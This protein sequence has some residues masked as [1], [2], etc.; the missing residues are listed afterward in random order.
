MI[1]FIHAADLHLGAPFVGLREF[2]SRIRDAL[3][4]APYLAFEYLVS[5]AI[6]RKVDFVLLAGD[7]F[8]QGGLNINAQIR[9]KQALE[10]LSNENI[11]VFIIY[12]NHDYLV[13]DSQML[14]YPENV[15]VFSSEGETFEYVLPNGERGSLSGFSYQGRQADGQIID[16]FPERSPKTDYHIGIWHGEVVT[17]KDSYSPYAPV[18]LQALEDKHYDY[19][20]LGHVHQSRQLNHH[21]TIAY[22]GTIQGRHVN[23]QGRKGCYEVTIDQNH[24]RTNFLETS[25][26]VFDTLD[27]KVSGEVTL[28][29]VYQVIEE[30]LDDIVDQYQKSILQLNLSINDNVSDSLKKQLDDSDYRKSLS[31]YNGPESFCYISKIHYRGL[32]SYQPLAEVTDIYDYY[33]HQE[34]TESLTSELFQKIPNHYHH[35]KKD[36]NYLKERIQ[37]AL[38]LIGGEID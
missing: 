15:F 3:F 29:K 5:E 11:P 2:P 9:F 24:I 19:W 31:R 10:I 30:A 25:Q 28:Q 27:L 8:D 21:G 33:Q 26:I 22:S 12:G 6:S 20:A 23:E 4:E 34:I 7:I 32:Q 35:V 18:T 16:H 14:H 38:Y 36:Q 17:N 13:N 1:K 37:E